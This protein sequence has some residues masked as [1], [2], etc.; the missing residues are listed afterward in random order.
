LGAFRDIPSIVALLHNKLTE[1][2]SVFKTFLSIPY[3]F[4]PMFFGVNG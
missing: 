2:T 4:R 3:K 1:S